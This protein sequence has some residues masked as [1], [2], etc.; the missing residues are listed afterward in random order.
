MPSVA[1]L[2]CTDVMDRETMAVW[3]G[4]IFTTLRENP[5]TTVRLTVNQKSKNAFTVQLDM[6]GKIPKNIAN[7]I[8]ESV[9]DDGEYREDED[10]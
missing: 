5:T 1:G 8:H 7:S 2:H 6:A 3:G 4:N 9:S 10:W